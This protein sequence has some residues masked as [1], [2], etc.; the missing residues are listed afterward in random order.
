MLLQE[1]QHAL[2][3]IIGLGQNGLSC[4]GENIILAVPLHLFGHI[5]V[6]DPCLSS[7]GVLLH[8]RPGVVGVLEA[9]L[10]GAVGGPV[11]GKLG[12]GILCQVDCV[13]RLIFR[14]HTEG[15]QSEAAG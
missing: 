14:P 12:Q 15:L 8:I 10:H 2:V 6:A 1:G 7:L 11:G 9:V 4:L 5:R 13:G 3:G